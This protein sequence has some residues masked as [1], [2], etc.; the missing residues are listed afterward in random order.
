MWELLTPA[1]CWLLSIAAAGIGVS[2]S[3]FAGVSMLHVL[4]FAYVFG[5]KASTGVLLPM[6]II[7]D[8]MA[9]CFFGK[10]A[11]WG[12]FRRLLPPAVIGVVIG[13]L[14]MKDLSEA[15][16]TPTVGVIIFVLTLLQVVR[17]WRPETFDKVPHHWT[18]AWTLGLL[19]GV[20]TMLANAAGPIVALFLLAVALPKLELVGTSAWFFLTIN[21]IKLPFSYFVLDLI[22]LESLSVNLLFAPVILVGMLG[23]KWLLGKMPQKLFD[24]FLLAFTG[25]VAIRMIFSGIDNASP[26]L[27][28]VPPSSPE[29]QNSR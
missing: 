16:F 17:L 9:I 20:A 8:L 19:A 25:F 4:I 12:E 2:K 10:K 24:S 7:G 21:V 13:T 11:Q 1:N 14:V 15:V 29:I 3:G 27:Q 23:G 5:A 6:L 22:S 28:P 18:F 26:Q